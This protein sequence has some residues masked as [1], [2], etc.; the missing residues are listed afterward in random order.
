MHSWLWF[1]ACL[2]WLIHA[3]AFAFAESEPL[4]ENPFVPA[5]AVG[6]PRLGQFTPAA[7]GAWPQLTI[8]DVGVGGGGVFV[9]SWPASAS[10]WSLEY[11]TRWP[12]SSCVRVS[13]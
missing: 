11:S 3:S 5:A 1:S 4:F 8:R 6:A 7:A 12:S 9:V 2:G 13:P 10:E